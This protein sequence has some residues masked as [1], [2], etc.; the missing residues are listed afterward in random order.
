MCYCD[1]CNTQT[2]GLRKNNIREVPVKGTTIN[3][4]YTGVFCDHCEIGRAHV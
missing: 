4:S 2:Q 1:V 3:V